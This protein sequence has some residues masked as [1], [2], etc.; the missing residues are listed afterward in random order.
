[1]S[2][3]D[4]VWSRDAEGCAVGN[5]HVRTVRGAKAFRQ[6]RDCRKYSRNEDRKCEQFSRFHRI[7]V[8]CPFPSATLTTSLFSAFV[9]TK[10]SISLL[11]KCAF[12]PY[13]LFPATVQRA[14]TLVDMATDGPWLRVYSTA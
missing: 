2:R 4:A 14:T 13:Y 8:F 6:S 3:P 1:M 5:Y 9:K 10:R 11:N 7:P 12:R